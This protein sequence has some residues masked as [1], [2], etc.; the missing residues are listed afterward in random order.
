MVISDLNSAKA[1]ATAARIN[2]ELG[3]EQAVAIAADVTDENQVQQ[4]IDQTLEHFGNVTTLVNNAGILFP[5]RAE[6]ISL[7]EWSQVIA[8]N[9]TATFLCS[10]AVIMPMRAAGHGRIINMSSS[11]G[12]SVST[13]GG[14]HYTAAKAG[15]LG[16]TRAFAKEYAREGILVNAVCPGLIATEMVRGTCSAQQIADYEESFPIH[17]LGSPDEVAEVVQFLSAGGSYITGASIDVNGGD[18]MI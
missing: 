2:R 8:V 10:R 5:T 15:V 6:D 16:L 1:Q 4:L 3:I 11:A 18:L 17:R 14:A 9:L 12:R 13:I 7:A